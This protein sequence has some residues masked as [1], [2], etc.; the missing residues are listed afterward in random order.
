MLLLLEVLFYLNYQKLSKNKYINVKIFFIQQIMR[1]T[2][3]YM[4]IV[5]AMGI[6][7][8][9]AKPY[10]P[11]NFSFS[12]VPWFESENDMEEEEKTTEED[13][14]KDMLASYTDDSEAKHKTEKKYTIKNI[15]AG[16]NLRPFLKKIETNPVLKKTFGN[17]KDLTISTLR[18][19]KIMIS[20][21]TLQKKV[22]IKVIMHFS[23]LPSHA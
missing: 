7:S 13:N 19:K 10:S 21:K 17:L 20:S 1:Y 18:R 14:E 3:L 22:F 6:N 2:M 15:L 8:Q 11:S 12:S 23:A 5:L 16:L 9:Q 4:M